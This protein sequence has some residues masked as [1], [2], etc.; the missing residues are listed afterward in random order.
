MVSEVPAAAELL[1]GFRGQ[2]P[3]D[4][5]SLYRCLETLADYAWADRALIAELDV[6]PIKVLPRGKGC[7]VVD[8][9]IV[10]RVA[11]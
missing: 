2:P 9:L 10:P 1:A 7:V 6:N 3:A 4:D 5:E 8:A 11:R